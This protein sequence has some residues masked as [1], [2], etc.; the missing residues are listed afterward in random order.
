[1][2]VWDS[3]H[4]GNGHFQHAM[5]DEADESEP[6]RDGHYFGRGD[7]RSV[8]PTDSHQAFVERDPPRSSL[9]HRLEGGENPSLVERPDDLV[10]RPDVFAAQR[11]ASASLRCACRSSSERD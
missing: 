5:I 2:Q 1:M 10:A 8:R 9:H 4:F 7:D 11:L 6:F 3:R